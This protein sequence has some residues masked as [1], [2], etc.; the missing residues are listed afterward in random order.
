MRKCQ[1]FSCGNV[2]LG[3]PGGGSNVQ[4]FPEIKKKPIQ[5]RTKGTAPRK[6]ATTWKLRRT[7]KALA[8]QNFEENSKEE[9]KR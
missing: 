3:T 9:K 8:V 7:R 4:H 5:E 2:L 1:K 6:R